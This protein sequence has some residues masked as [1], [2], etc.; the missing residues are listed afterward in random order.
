MKGKERKIDSAT[1]A[2]RKQERAKELKHKTAC[3]ATRRDLHALQKLHEDTL[4]YFFTNSAMQSAQNLHVLE[5]YK[6]PQLHC[7]S[8]MYTIDTKNYVRTPPYCHA[9]ARYPRLLHV[10]AIRIYG[11]NIPKSALCTFTAQ[12]DVYIQI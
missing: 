1:A 5:P 6:F 9:C 10:H 7:Y 8:T 11:Y 3:E 4:H 12:S 2:L